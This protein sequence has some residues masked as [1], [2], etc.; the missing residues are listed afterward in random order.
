MFAEVEYEYKPLIA[1]SFLNNRK[2]VA[3]GRVHR[4]PADGFL[5]LG[6]QPFD[7][8][9]SPRVDGNDRL[10]WLQAENAA[11]RSLVCGLCVG[12][13]RLSEVHREI[14]VQAFDMADRFAGPAAENAQAGS[15]ANGPAELIRNLRATVIEHSGYGRLS[16]RR[17]RV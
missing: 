15:G 14:V 17:V 4:P 5:D 11:L 16:P 8:L 7:L 6:L 2:I 1:S 9:E 10:D 12:L 13:S 3:R